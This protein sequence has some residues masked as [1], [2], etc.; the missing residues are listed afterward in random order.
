MLLLEYVHMLSN[1]KWLDKIGFTCKTENHATI[2]IMCMKIC[3]KME[4]AC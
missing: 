4:T 1:R 3:N 2:K